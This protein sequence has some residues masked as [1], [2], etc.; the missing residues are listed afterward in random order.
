MSLIVLVQQIKG[1]QQAVEVLEPS[2]AAQ[3]LVP[4][5]DLVWG[6]PLLLTLRN[7]LIWISLPALLATGI[8]AWLT[9]DTMR[10]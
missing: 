4:L 2:L 6:T 10:R 9:S 8:A 5:S 3:V 1:L 7:S